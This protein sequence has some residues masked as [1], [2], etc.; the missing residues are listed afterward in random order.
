MAVFQTILGIFKPEDDETE[1]VPAA[2]DITYTI[3]PLTDKQIRELIKLNRR[4]FR[5]GENYTKTTFNYLFNEPN[6]LSYQI[7]ANNEQMA[8]FVFV[9]LNPNGTAHLTTI[10]VAPEHRRRGLAE[11][12]L[13]HIEKVL[14]VKGVS[15]IVLEVRV[16]NL[17][18]RRL[19]EKCGYTAVRTIS[20]YYSDGEDC[21]LMLRA[22]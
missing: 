10:G 20:S 19:Y 4:C 2:P 1:G 7:A 11:M 22:I 12:L 9:I 16:S 18:A 17:P 5:N 15:T 13:K 14:A 6:V 3:R 8:A 21:L